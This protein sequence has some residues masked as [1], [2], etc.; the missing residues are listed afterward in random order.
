[1]ATLKVIDRPYPLSDNHVTRA[2]QA[3]ARGPGRRAHAYEAGQKLPASPDIEKAILGAILNSPALGFPIFD[4]SAKPGFF[5]NPC[6]RELYDTSLRFFTDNGKLDMIVLTEHLRDRGLLDK[7]G[8]AGYVTEL[9]TGPAGIGYSVDMLD[10]YIQELREKW[11]RR[12]ILVRSFSNAKAAA[13]NSELSEVMAKMRQDLEYLDRVATGNNVLADAV[14]FT[15]GKCPPLPPEIV[16]RLLHQGSKMIVGG[17]SK[18]RKTMALIDLA[19]S[20]ATGSDWWGFRTRKGAICYIN[21]EI[22]DPF[23][24]YRVNEVCIAKEIAPDPGTF[25]AWNLRGRADG[26]DRLREQIVMVLKSRQFVLVIIDPIYKALGGRDEN[27]AGDVAAM[28]NEVEKIAV[29]TGSAVA[30][31]AHY[32]KGDQSIKESVDRIGGSGVFARDPDT[33]LTMTAHEKEHCF[34]VDATLRNFAPMQPFVVKWFWPTFERD[35]DDLDPKALKRQRG[36]KAKYLPEDLM[37]HF[38]FSEP[39]SITKLLKKPGV[40]GMSK[41]TLYRLVDKLLMDEKIEETEDGF[42]LFSQNVSEKNDL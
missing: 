35:S 11:L 4:R 26:L 31:G 18:G 33:I 36:A 9:F 1:M 25:Y 10:Y 17:T 24:W 23:F 27:R 19:V 12:Q 32:S 5:F 14:N 30:F 21:F 20:V 6:N 38:T 37:K 39:I 29:E 13:E 34:T 16:Y 8:G 2:P 15:N 7:L 42:T 28:L 22:Q 41:S 40:R 3:P